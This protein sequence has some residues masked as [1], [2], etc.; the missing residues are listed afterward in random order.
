MLLTLYLGYG[1][2]TAVLAIAMGEVTSPIQNVWFLLKNMRYRYR[3]ADQVFAYISWMYS[4]FYI[5][6]RSGV[7]LFMVRCTCFSPACQLPP[8]LPRRLSHHWPLHKAACCIPHAGGR[9]HT[10]CTLFILQRHC[11][12]MVPLPAFAAAVCP[13][14]QYLLPLRFLRSGG[15]QRS[16]AVAR[17]PCVYWP[18]NRS[19]ISAWKA[20]NARPVTH[21]SWACGQVQVEQLECVVIVARPVPAGV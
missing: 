16:H 20:C 4:A 12:T 6:I 2:I 8:S 3:L 13:R 7:G 5:F 10:T 19:F 15:C 1:N 11:F 21:V 9:R 18:I 17:C 14:Y